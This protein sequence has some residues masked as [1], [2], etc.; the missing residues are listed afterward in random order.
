MQTKTKA[1]RTTSKPRK[2]YNARAGHNESGSA[3]IR[4]EENPSAVIADSLFALKLPNKTGVEVFTNT[5]VNDHTADLIAMYTDLYQALENALKVLKKRSTGFNPYPTLGIATSIDW[6]L[7]QF[8]KHVKPRHLDYNIEFD[9][10]KNQYYFVLYKNCNYS[11]MYNVIQVRHV[12][13]HL[14]SKSI[15]IHDSFL[16]FIRLFSIHTGIDFWF[17]GRVDWSIDWIGERVK[18]ED[19]EDEVELEESRRIWE[20]YTKPEGQ[21]NQCQRAIKSLKSLSIGQFKKQLASLN[22]RHELVKTMKCVTD[23]LSKNAKF[24]IHDFEYRFS[25]EYGD[26]G[27]V[28][29]FPD[30]FA[31]M[32]DCNDSVFWFH[33]EMVDNDAQEGV[34]IPT[35]YIPISKDSKKIDCNWFN[36]ALDY[37]NALE[38]QIELINKTIKIYEPKNGRATR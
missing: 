7:R 36:A 2:G 8:E 6:V 14:K 37:P 29:S 9:E 19:Y 3:R 11:C 22:Q 16:Q 18:S 4:R 25:D 30:Q 20:D 35:V 5:A 15:A 34:A 10:Y 28:L 24:N 1:K 17:S 13:K 26:D 21:A 27:P 12:L 32:W 33:T 31:I 38:Q 23:F